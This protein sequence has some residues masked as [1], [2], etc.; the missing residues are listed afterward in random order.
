[1]IDQ[2]II[3]DKA[4]FDDFGAS[5]A[6]RTIGQPPKKSIK[7]TVP[8]SNMTYDFS[9]I[10]GEIYWEER[11]LEYVF[12][13]IAP[14]PEKLEDMKTAFADWVMNVMNEEIH[15]PFIPEYHFVGTYAE[16]EFEDED[17]VEKT[18]ASVTFTAYPYK[19]A[20]HATGAEVEFGPYYAA[21]D[22]EV[23]VYNASSHPVTAAA[24]VK[25]ADE[26]DL[27]RFIT[28]ESMSFS[29][30]LTEGNEIYLTLP[31]GLST[32]RISNTNEPCGGSVTITYREEVF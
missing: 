2:L 30:S 7:E 12:E 8:F 27:T 31:T 24:S 13:M 26:S 6:Q 1:M 29:T 32:F 14:T 17:G 19:I 21:R 22:A 16:M 10:N 25:F 15:D 23:S 4:S 3:G 18:T 11:E 5:L 20:N 28:F 9:K